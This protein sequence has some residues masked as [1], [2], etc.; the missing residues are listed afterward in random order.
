VRKPFNK[1][2]PNIKVLYVSILILAVTFLLNLFIKEKLQQPQKFISAIE[3]IIDNNLL[4]IQE[5]NNIIKSVFIE[6]PDFGFSDIQFEPTY[7]TYVFK[8][9]SLAYWSD[10][11]FVPEYRYIAGN[12]LYSFLNLNNGKF[13][14]KR[15]NVVVKNNYFEIYTLLPIFVSLDIDNQYLRSGYN[16]DIIPNSNIAINALPEE[17]Y[18]PVKAFDKHYL[19]SAQFGQ[20]FV[21]QNEPLQ[22]F[23]LLML[24]V[25]I[26]LL[27]YYF[28]TWV[29][30]LAFRR[31]F[32]QGFI[33]LFVGLVLMRISLLVLD[34]PN[35]IIQLSIF[36]PRYYASSMINPSLGDLLIN[37]LIVYIL[38]WFVFKYFFRSHIFRIIL[39]LKYYLRIIVSF[40]IL[41][42]SYFTLFLHY[43]FIKTLYLHSQWTL[44]INQSIDFTFLKVVCFLIFAIIS[45][46]YFLAGHVSYNIFTRLNPTPATWFTT[47]IISS[48]VIVTMAHI[49]D[50]DFLLISL[51]NVAYF[52]LLYFLQLPKKLVHIK[53]ITFIY[54][55]ISAM[56]SAFV[57]AYSVYNFEKIRNIND[58]YKFGTQLLI[59]N[60]IWGEYLLAE[61]TQR[62]QNDPFINNRMFSP[63]SS[64]DVIEQKIRRIFL[65]NYFD[66]YDIQIY[67]FNSQGDPYDFSAVG[68]DY[69]TIRS[70]YENE[71]S[72]TEH[73]GLYF[74]HQIGP[75][76]VKRYLNFIEIKRYGINIGYI[77]MDL[78]LKRI[79]PSSV[80]PQLLVDQR[81]LYP[82]LN[83]SY[84]YGIIS[85]G[86][87]VYN[88]GNFNYIRDFNTTDLNKKMLY[89]GGVIR[90]GYH[91]FAV[92]GDNERTI[93]VTSY[94]QPVRT[95]I[96]NFSFFFLILIFTILLLLIGY[97]IFYS[98]QELQLN[99]ATKIQ[100]Y[101]NFAFFLPL[102]V[103]SVV[104]LSV[105]ST[106][107]TRE[108]NR[109]YLKR[110]ESIS[111][112]IVNS[113]DNYLKNVSG[114]EALYAD[115]AQMA[116]FTEND[117]NLY[118]INGRLIATSQPRIFEKD[119]LSEYL[120]PVAM[121]EI[122]ERFN[123][124]LI[125]NEN[126]SHLSYKAAY[127]GVK[128]FE[129]GNLIGILSIPFFESQYELDRQV[130]DVITNIINIF[131]FLFI[132]FLI[133]SYF[134]SKILT[135]PLRYITQK[136][137]RTTLDHNEPIHWNSDDEIGLMVGEYNRML[138]KLEASKEALAA[139]EKESA[140]REMAKQVA[141]EIKN[142]LTPMK[143][144]LQ[145]LQKK[146]ADQKAD[147]ADVFEKPI[148]TLLHQIDTLNDIATSFS[149]FAQMPIPK[150]EKFEIT[151]LMKKTINL[152]SSDEKG[153][154]HAY[155]PEGELYVIGDSQLMSRIL[156]NLIINGF[157]SVP[158][159]RTPNI[160]VHLKST[161]K[162]AIIEIRDNGTGIPEAIRDK[163]FIPNFSTKYAGSGIGLAIAKRGVEH[164][165][166]R[167]W[168][169]TD[170]DK[171]TSFFIE[172]PLE[173]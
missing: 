111:N 109:Q 148:H 36:N 150:N 69:F 33:L 142:P 43:Y 30:I 115:L 58:K 9:R 144:T 107:Y 161:E 73:E 125:V 114:K 104:T 126:I 11:Q 21:I 2:R 163:I 1:Y 113:L 146:L 82:Y 130:I 71:F 79:I 122:K 70:F 14:V 121:A 153:K 6:N 95:V 172:L 60:D 40:S 16:F 62:I 84:S 170:E 134:A 117:V 61:A 165:G 27:V 15:Q 110:A 86:E 97:A 124:E 80:Y 123:N 53:F 74:D 32:L 29:R 168:Y 116:R 94:I 93:I 135:H 96:S 13:V 44:D 108:I 48:V 88:S 51:V 23:L 149:A 75:N 35:S 106:T 22:I 128:S 118:S 152:F 81:F 159:D 151:S 101:M 67:L 154:I 42:L 171:G 145:L 38:I 41:S 141:H 7:P 77:V 164:A 66:K 65:N 162:K 4:Q 157:Q 102:F 143:L 90:D 112:N 68:A 3:D 119:L 100:L 20:D 173:N 87:L 99:F 91:H 103:V 17:S 127:I 19:F 131:S 59:E 105:I 18:L 34:L 147:N 137:R 28:F 156:S 89:T 120:N 50:V 25:G 24:T 139:S 64:K 129:T 5:D 76:L 47:F 31:K 12:Y 98:F 37:I 138:R 63:F 136:I 56:V 72:L 166:G 52:L 160:E 49:I 83:R 92:Q 45:S 55:F 8:N 155:L 140:W 78:K 167:I 10:N 169:E 132:I 85:Q 133:I 54:F 46:I 26:L 39:E 158:K 57:A